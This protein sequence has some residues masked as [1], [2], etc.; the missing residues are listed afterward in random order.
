MSICVSDPIKAVY[1]DIDV[2][3]PFTAGYKLTLEH[4]THTFQ[5]VELNGK[6]TLTNKGMACPNQTTKQCPKW[7]MDCISAPMTL[8][9]GIVALR[10]DFDNNTFVANLTSAV[11]D[12]LTNY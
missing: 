1:N 8:G 7:V 4:S 9:S 3:S 6:R 5:R 11:I 2:H 10:T 12:N